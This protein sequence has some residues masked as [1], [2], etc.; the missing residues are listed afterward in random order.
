[1]GGHRRLGGAE[2]AATAEA[3]N[4]AEWD[5]GRLTD[6]HVLQLVE[7]WQLTHT[8]VVDGK[9]GP[10]TR[11][12]LD[13]ALN[14][15]SVDDY[16]LDERAPERSRP[17]PAFQDH[18]FARLPRTHA[19]IVALYGNP[20]DDSGALSPA[21]ERANMTL[22]RDLPGVPRGKLYVHRLAEP[23]LRE[24]LRRCRRDAPEYEI[25]KIGCFSFRHMRHDPK[26]PLS[27][28]SWG[29]AVDIRPRD[30][31][32]LR[33]APGRAPEAFSR[34]WRRLWPNGMPESFV[35]A[36]ESCGWAW[37]ADWDEDMSSADHT[38]L[39]PMHFELVDRSGG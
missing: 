10:D 27:R 2:S 6:H 33:F 21:W 19:E 16:E 13:A 15:L 5:A 31:R 24:A 8:L 22:A 39:D 4:R 14:I 20:Q 1:M 26:R 37:G 18:P 32:S 25:S 3:Y 29:I 36:W 38:Y 34:E 11:R 28:H 23:A 30:N 12:S 7:H 9:A 35:R 17:L